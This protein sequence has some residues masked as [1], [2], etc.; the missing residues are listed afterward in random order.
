MIIANKALTMAAV[1]KF[2]IISAEPYKDKYDNRNTRNTLLSFQW[3][4]TQDVKTACS[5][6]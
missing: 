2:D 4:L 1:A 6:V 3:D 5:S